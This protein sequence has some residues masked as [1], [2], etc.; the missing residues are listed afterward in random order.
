MF[1]V[2]LEISNAFMRTDQGLVIC[3]FAIFSAS[4][5]VI[6][7]QNRVIVEKGGTE[8]VIPG[9]IAAIHS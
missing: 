2:K 9:N 5:L 1:A 4:V 7:I 3:Y 8:E 6:E